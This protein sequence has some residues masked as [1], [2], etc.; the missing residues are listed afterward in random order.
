MLTIALMIGALS[1]GGQAHAKSPAAACSTLP[2][3]DLG[4]ITGTYYAGG[5]GPLAPLGLVALTS[6]G[7]I[8]PPTMEQGKAGVLYLEGFLPA[9]AASTDI[10]PACPDSLVVGDA[11][12]I[13]GE[14]DSSDY[15]PDAEVWVHGCQNT[16]QVRDGTFEMPVVAGDCDLVVQ[17]S[18]FKWTWRSQAVAVSPRPG[19]RTQVTLPAGSPIAWAALN[20]AFTDKGTRVDSFPAGSAAA[21]SGLAAGDIIVIIDGKDIRNHAPAAVLKLLEGPIGTVLEI[22]TDTGAKHHV[23]RTTSDSS[24][25][26]GNV[27]LRVERVGTRIVVAEAVGPAARKGI[28]PGD[29][30]EASGGTPAAEWEIG[31]L[32]LSWRGGGF[33][34]ISVSRAGESHRY[35]VPVRWT[36]GRYPRMES[37]ADL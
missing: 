33:R 22:V 10:G 19:S 35:V 4:M 23:E 34:R 30:I 11:A 36:H 15:P 1:I 28:R 5:S 20:L 29:V 8:I 32:T 17:A 24:F 31:N 16:A 12:V 18:D 13:V 37:N 14:V 3:P 6:A 9:H 26:A 21:A 27:G 7:L 25:S 2:I